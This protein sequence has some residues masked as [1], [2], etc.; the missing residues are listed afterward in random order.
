MYFCSVVF[1]FAFNRAM[2][3]ADLYKTIQAI[4][5]CC[6]RLSMRHLIIQMI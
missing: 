2:Q 6:R 5:Y 1:E 3:T 4:S